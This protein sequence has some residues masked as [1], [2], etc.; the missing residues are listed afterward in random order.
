[1]IRGTTAHF[2]FTLPYEFSEIR[3]ATIEFSQPNNEGTFQ[4]PLP[5]TKKMTDEAL[6][7]SIQSNPDNPFLLCVTL[8]PDETARFSDKIKARVQLRASSKGGHVF[9]SK[10]KLVTVY[11]MKDSILE[12][13]P[14]IY[15][16][17]DD[18]WVYLDGGSIGR[19]DLWNLKMK[20]Q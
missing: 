8:S 11:P 5:I 9:A 10:E 19:W 1:M 14:P 17:D 4:G 12:E 13:N 20:K 7:D 6:S 3:W 15:D 16:D 18:G 2:R